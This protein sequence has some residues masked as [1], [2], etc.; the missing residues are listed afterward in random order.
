MKR[1]SGQPLGAFADANIFTPLGMTGT[2]FR[3]DPSVL[4][5]NRAENYARDDGA[6][7]LV[8]A[9]TQPGAVGN[10]GLWTTTRDLLRWAENLANPKVG[11]ASLFA[12]M[13]KPSGVPS[14]EKTQWGLGFDINEHRDTTVVGH[15]GG[16]K[17][18]DNYFAWYPQQ[19]LAIAVLCNTDNT[20]SMLIS[21]QIADLYLVPPPARAS[22]A[23]A[24][25]APATV[26]LSADQLESKAALYRE[27]G[28]NMFFR[29]FVRD[30]E[31]RGA[32]GTGTGD[33]FPLAPESESGFIIPGTRFAVE[34]APAGTARALTMRSFDG[35]TQT[36]T[37]ERVEPFAPS[38]AQLR[39]YAGQ[40]AS[41]EL[42]VVWTLDVHD[43]TLV[44]RRPGSADTVVQPLA[45]D[46]FTTVGDFMR[47]SRDA[48]GA[49]TGFT[50]VAS[51]A[52]GLRFERTR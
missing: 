10:S 7:R 9:N 38:P 11:S 27:V 34:F 43:S 5:S 42:D 40:Y 52:R 19:R 21:R 32:L 49:I 39:A 41:D 25:P 28:G 37:F 47:F 6:W 50:L 44:I 13:Q 36:G 12:E 26:K 18:I 33:S 1:V 8:H 35:H 3:D 31:L 48:R 17:G 4:L 14:P 2:R 23:P 15:G 22:G 51:G 24:A 29:T 20:G 46:M 45:T 30:G 16:D